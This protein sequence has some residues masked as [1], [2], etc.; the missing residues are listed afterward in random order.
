VGV[1]KGHRDCQI[2]CAETSTSTRLHRWEC[3]TCA[4]QWKQFSNPSELLH[5]DRLKAFVERMSLIFDWIIFGISAGVGGFTDSSTSRIYCDGVLFVVRAGATDIWRCY[6][7]SAEVRDKNLLGGVRN[8][9]R[10][11]FVWRYYYG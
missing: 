4:I 9:W 6:K 7:A 1:I 5:S 2:T 3:A 10:K 8:A 11:A